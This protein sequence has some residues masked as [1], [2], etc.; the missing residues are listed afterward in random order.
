MRITSEEF[1]YLAEPFSADAVRASLLEM[2][3]FKASGLDG[4]HAVFYQHNWDAV[5]AEVTDYCTS[6]L[7]GQ[8]LLNMN[9]TYVVLILR[10]NAR[11]V[12]WSFDPLFFFCDVLDKIITKN[13]KSVERRSF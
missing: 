8:Q 9:A 1:H 3:S 6:V 12:S 4:N 7:N 2:G 13:C 5:G 10:L 11:K